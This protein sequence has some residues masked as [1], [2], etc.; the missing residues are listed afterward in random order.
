MGHILC[1][2]ISTMEIPRRPDKLLIVDDEASIRFAMREY[3]TLQGF[4]VDCAC[5]KGEA[6]TFLEKERYAAVIADLRLSGT[7]S[8][9]GLDIVSC[10][11]KRYPLMRIIILTAHGSPE[12]E[13]EAIRR[14][15]DAFLSKPKP[16]QEVARILFDLLGSKPSGVKPDP[17]EVKSCP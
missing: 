12:I 17:G 13:A 5:D 7:G 8:T 1:S 14:G 16:L 15:A 10:A 9:E 11:R 6:K 3:F 4:E 2:G